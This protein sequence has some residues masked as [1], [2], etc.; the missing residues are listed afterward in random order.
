MAEGN[1]GFRKNEDVGKDRYLQP[2]ILKISTLESPGAGE[3]LRLEGHLGGT[4]VAE[5]RRSC[6][7]VL[8][9][10]RQLTLDLAGVSFID[11]DGVRLLK[12][13]KL[14]GVELRSCSPFVALRLQE[15]GVE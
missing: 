4:C 3:T 14:L 11:R 8:L 9:E 6:D 7:Q 1:F 13:L 5:L 15:G 10:C 12:R 2:Q